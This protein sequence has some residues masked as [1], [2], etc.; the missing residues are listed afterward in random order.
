MLTTRSRNR[1]TKTL[2]FVF[3]QDVLSISLNAIFFAF[4]LFKRTFL[5]NRYLSEAAGDLT[6]LWGF[7]NPLRSSRPRR[8]ESRSRDRLRRKPRGRDTGEIRPDRDCFVR[9]HFFQEGKTSEEQ[10]NSRM[11]WR[12]DDDK[13]HL[14][15]RHRQRRFFNWMIQSP[16]WL[17]I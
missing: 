8:L 1:S 6:R 5:L 13:A 15:I 14:K 9:T 17:K 10:L 2:F 7:A 3:V 4:V 12:H 16:G 11:I